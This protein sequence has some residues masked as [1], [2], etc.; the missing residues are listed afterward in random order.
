V[1]VVAVI[2]FLIP[3]QMLVYLEVQV[4]VVQIM[5]LLVALELLD[6]ATLEEQVLLVFQQHNELVEVEVEQEQLDLRQLLVVMAA[7]VICG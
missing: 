3:L 5:V 1:A 6:K 7:K 2:M 4:E